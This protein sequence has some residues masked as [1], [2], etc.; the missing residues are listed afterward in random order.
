MTTNRFNNYG[1][2]IVIGRQK[3]PIKTPVYFTFLYKLHTLLTLK[4]QYIKSMLI[5]PNIFGFYCCPDKK[6]HI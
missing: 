3:Y 5:N 1:T 2:S 4:G 6:V